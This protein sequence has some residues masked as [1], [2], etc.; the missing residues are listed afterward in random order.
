MDRASS[1]ATRSTSSFGTPSS[2]SASG[3][4]RH[5]HEST[6]TTRP[7]ATSRA[8][9]RNVSVPLNAAPHPVT[10]AS[11]LPVPRDRTAMGGTL[12]VP[13][14]AHASETSSATHDTVPSPPA[15]TNRRSPVCRCL[16]TSD[17]SLD[18]RSSRRRMYSSR[19]TIVQFACVN[20]E[21]R[22]I[23]RKV[24]F[25]DARGDI[26]ARWIGSG[27]GRAGRCCSRG[28]VRRARTSISLRES[29]K[30][31]GW[32]C[33]WTRG[34][35]RIGSRASGGPNKARNEDPTWKSSG[36][37]RVGTRFDHVPGGCRCVCL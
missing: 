21:N 16:D 5:S 32:N 29:C 3:T 17:V 24:N 30:P 1:E 8:N 31:C 9:C 14:M 33:G 37:R 4:A 23:P 10:R 25:L 11:S 19:Y 36:S 6:P 27:S 28:T 2:S 22:N 26:S 20:G 35:V 18:M 7:H 12:R 34:D 13:T 15:A